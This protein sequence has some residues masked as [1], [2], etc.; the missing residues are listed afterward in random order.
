MI[1]RYIARDPMGRRVEG[2]IESSSQEQVAL[3]LKGRALEPVL[4]RLV[5]S[6][7]SGRAEKRPEAALETLPDFETL[8]DVSA[9]TSAETPDEAEKGGIS[10]WFGVLLLLG[11]LLMEFCG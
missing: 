4:I 7:G 6:S 5:I 10:R 11:Y 9:P 8:P 1:Y 3:E 2:E